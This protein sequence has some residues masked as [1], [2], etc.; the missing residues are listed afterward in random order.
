MALEQWV[1]SLSARAFVYSIPGEMSL[2]AEVHH[3]PGRIGQS[4]GLR[5]RT[6]SI[7][8]FCLLGAGTKNESYATDVELPTIPQ[9][10]AP[11]AL[12]VHVDTVR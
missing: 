5:S 7:S 12:A 3:S 11:G 8:L 9:E 1:G 4:H 2:L 6:L 10:V